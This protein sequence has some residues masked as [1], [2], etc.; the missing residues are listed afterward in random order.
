MEKANILLDSLLSRVN[1]KAAISI[2]TI[3]QRAHQAPAVFFSSG[4]FIP[5]L[6]YWR[7][8]RWCSRVQ[9]HQLLIVNC[10]KK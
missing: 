2:A 4:E 7:W 6:F 5:C 10:M 3:Q 1:K 9:L 8:N